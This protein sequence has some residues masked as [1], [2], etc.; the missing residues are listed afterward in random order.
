MNRE[1]AIDLNHLLN[2]EAIR[3]RLLLA[4][5][6]LSAYEILKAT[7]IEGVAQILVYLP[8]PDEDGLLALK[9]MVPKDIFTSLYDQN[10]TAYRVLVEKYEREL[11]IRFDERSRRGLIPSC[12]WLE[13]EGVLLA[14]DIQAIRAIRNYRNEIAHELPNLLV[15]EGSHLDLDQLEGIIAIIRKVEPFFARLDAEIPIDVPDERIMSGGQI[16][17]SL[18][19]DAVIDYLQQLTE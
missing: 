14:E 16:I 7:V 10:V 18:L 4:S 5:L 8:E 11:G 12:D 2:P 17:L 15:S 3:I 9:A 6:Y 1:A 13:A 19:W